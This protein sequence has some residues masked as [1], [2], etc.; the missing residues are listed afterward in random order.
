MN[1]YRLPQTLSGEINSLKKSI[2]DFR[3]GN[4]HLTQFKGIRVPFGV[5]EQR[6][7]D[8]YMM[9]IRCAAG[10]ATPAQLLKT[11]ELA[12]QYGSN[13]IHITT[14]Q[15]MQIHDVTLEDVPTIMR[16][17]QKVG[18]ATRGGGGN[19]VRNITASYDSGVNP[20]EVF[21]VEPYAV[22][23]TSHLIA[24]ADSW[25]LPRK[26]KVTFSSL[27]IDNA[28]ATI[29]DVGCI[30]RIKDGQK[31]FQVY[32]AGGMG[33][34]SRV[35]H[36]LDEF[37]PADRLLYTVKAVKALFYK[38]GNRKNKHRN[39]LRF[40][41]EDLGE[42]RFLELFTQELQELEK[43]PAL[44]LDVQDIPNAAASE[45]TIDAIQVEDTAYTLW[46]QR[47][48]TR[49]QQPGL[50]SIKIPLPLGD[51]HGEDALKLAQLLE[52]FGENVLRFSMDQN[53]HLRNIPETYLGNIFKGISELQTLSD[54]PALF[55]KMIACT[56]ANTCRLGICLPRG[57]TPAVRKALLNSDLNLEQ[58]ADF[59]IHIS[60]CPNACG[61]HVLGDLG[62]FGKVR[63]KEGHAFPAYNVL[64][65]AVIEPGKSHF[66][67]AVGWVPAYDVP[68]A[69]R[70]ILKAF[71]PQKD[72]YA[73]FAEYVYNGG[74]AEISALCES[75][76]DIPDFQDD[77]NYYFDWGAEEIFST[78]G[79]GQGE[80][81]AGLFDLIDVD[82]DIIN[83]NKALAESS[84]NQE[85]IIAA[86]YNVVFSAS[87]MLLVTRGIDPKSDN[88]V[89]E[90]F[91]T[92][93]IQ[94][95]LIP[96]RFTELIRLAQTAK[97]SALPKRKEDVLALGDAVISL[98]E[99]MDNSLTFPVQKSP[100]IDRSRVSV[101]QGEKTETVSNRDT[102]DKFKDY[103]GVKCPMNFVKTK[104]DLASMQTGQTLEIYLDDGDPIDNVPRSVAEEGHKILEQRR[105]EDYWTVL[106]EKT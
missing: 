102:S 94:E 17:L 28:N 50:L 3:R 64:A 31:G 7:D 78:A 73:S 87:R 22:A 99:S 90:H 66:G 76:R 14:R 43:T 100:E 2:T 82:R 54:Q 20:Q 98:Y 49:Q 19:T 59:K 93:F 105:I 84:D 39:R 44:A 101:Q 74:Q 91:I 13:I 32:V 88:T 83:T 72:R 58:Y 61:Q 71:L 21:D 6:K 12:G 24:E 86:L 4:M 85:H 46:Q 79:M 36:L 37:V 106:I 5:Y 62:F 53:I 23:L 8:T 97:Y 104:I 65:G 69:V 1:F 56:G 10:G 9:R 75:Y 42:E 15:E 55:G 35:G 45:I 34:I 47:Y 16:E 96:D 51:I 30:A 60:G 29:Q 26:F 63:R 18:L 52:P 89:F 92:F 33:A 68:N 40:L 11:A 48:V 41:W 81:S 57:M 80:C 25:T 103:R 77:K 70:D 27:A 38:H 67:V 95:G